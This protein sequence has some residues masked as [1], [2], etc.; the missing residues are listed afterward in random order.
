MKIIVFKILIFSIY[1]QLNAQTAPVISQYM[2]SGSIY[3]PA[4]TGSKEALAASV[5]HKNQWIGIKG[6]PI[7]ELFTLHAPLKKYRSAVGVAFT[8]ESIGIFNKSRLLVNYAYRIPAGNGKLAMGLSAGF[9]NTSAHYHKI[10]L[11]EDNDRAFTG[12]ASSYLYPNFGLGC[13]YYSDLFYWGFSIPSIGNAQSAKVGYDNIS[14]DF[15]PANYTYIFATGWKMFNRND[16]F[17]LKPLFLLK[18]NNNFKFQ[19]D[20]TLFGILHK[21]IW[22][23]TTFR[24][25]NNM[26]VLAKYHINNQLSIGYAYDMGIGKLSNTSSGSHEI[27]L[28]YVFDYL[29][30]AVKPRL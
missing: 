22:M 15:S 8:H 6:A 9:I 5:I 28:Q 20:L 18:Y 29:V 27:M 14:L 25:K 17:T 26:A 1:I 13:Y 16:K 2:F 24:I 12:Q 23:G 4:Y 11:I 19:Y 3:N 21:K 7:T 10:H 30:K